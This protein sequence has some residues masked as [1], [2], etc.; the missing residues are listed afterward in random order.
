MVKVIGFT[1]RMFMAVFFLILCGALG[2]AGLVYAEDASIVRAMQVD[3]TV[4]KNGA[5]MK[6]GDVIQRDDK[7]ESKANSAAIITWSNGSMVELYPETTLVLRGVI[8]EGDN[9][10][11]RTLLTLEKGRIFA[12][13]Q[14]P[15][16]IFTHFEIGVGNVPVMAQGAEFALKYDESEKK[17]T[18]WSLLGTVIIETSEKRVRVEDGQQVVL[19]V[20]GS[21]EAPVQMP[22]KIRYALAKTSKRLGG[23]LLIEEELGAGGPLKAKIGGVRNRR[24][25]APYTV[26][27]KAIIGGGSGRIKSIRWD[28]GDGE[29]AEGKTAQHTFTQGV[30]VVVLTVEDDNGQKT[31]SQISISVEINCSC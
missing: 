16:H 12:K 25:G 26:Q 28:F 2:A 27:F 11:E 21:P 20:G 29:S 18:V 23:S 24:G 3:G 30:Y 8:F 6:D 22:D 4:L 19:K 10:L 15:E 1:K 17:F 13:A 9:K 7:I 5:P 14:T 31:T